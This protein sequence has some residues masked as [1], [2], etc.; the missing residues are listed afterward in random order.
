MSADLNNELQ[1]LEAELHLL[2]PCVPSE[3]LEA[4]VQ[5]GLDK[6]SQHEKWIH[7]TWRV[8]AVCGVAAAM[9]W[10]GT[11]P[12]VRS[13][14]RALPA[15]SVNNE[16][17]SASDDG[18]VTLADGTPAWRYRMKYLETVSWSGGGRTVTLAAP[19]EELRIVPLVAY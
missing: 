2:R 3:F 6:L 16:L 5:A 7:P 17:R 4:R 10:L 15:V 8:L 14:S 1:E 12:P 13:A 18:V 9:V 11:L 19:H